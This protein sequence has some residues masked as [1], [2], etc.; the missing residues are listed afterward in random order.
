MLFVGLAGS[1]LEMISV[2]IACTLL[3]GAKRKVTL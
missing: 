2:C 3:V 1:V